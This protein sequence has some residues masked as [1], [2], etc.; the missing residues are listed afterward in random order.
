MYHIFNT[1]PKISHNFQGFHHYISSR[2]I[3]DLPPD[4]SLDRIPNN[5]IVHLE[6][7]LYVLVTTQSQ[8]NEH[9]RQTKGPQP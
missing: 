5:K 2:K 4:E 8:I 9:V 3:Y 7:H 1:S 6:S